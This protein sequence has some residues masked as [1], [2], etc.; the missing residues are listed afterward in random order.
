MFVDL[1]SS[2]LV[3]VRCVSTIPA[4]VSKAFISGFSRAGQSCSAVCVYL[5]YAFLYLGVLSVCLGMGLRYMYSSLTT[6]KETE[7]TDARTSLVSFAASVQ[8]ASVG[9][10]RTS[11]ATSTS[12]RIRTKRER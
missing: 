8:E 11:H 6:K 5:G 12:V 10:A 3:I 4:T 2:L 9:G 1:M 7:N